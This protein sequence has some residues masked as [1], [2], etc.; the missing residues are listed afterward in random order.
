MTRYPAGSASRILLAK[1]QGDMDADIMA[2]SS[3]HMTSSDWMLLALSG[4]GGQQS[5][6][7]LGRAYVQRL[8]ESGDIHVAV[9]I[10]LGM[11]DYHDAIEVYVSHYGGTDPD[12]C[13]VPR[14]LGTTGRHCKEMGRMGCATWPE[15]LAIRCFACT[16]Q[17]STEPWTSPSAVQ[18]NFQ[19]IT[20]SIPEVLSPPLSPPG[21]QGGPQRSI[22]KSSALKLITSFGDQSQRSRLYSQGDGG[23]TPV[24]AGVTPI[25]D[26]AISSGASYEAATALLRPSTNSSF[27]T[28]TSA[29]AGG[30]SLRGRLPSI[31]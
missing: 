11:G 19:S 27:N 15:Q 3:E 12:V 1:W 20:P 24:A 2:G 23:Q 9:T 7:K 22:A 28:P 17:E 21:A 13:R 16:D 30:S 10:M 26:S 6:H 31:G 18:L 8:L 5:Q 14:R 4:I 25:A 29:R